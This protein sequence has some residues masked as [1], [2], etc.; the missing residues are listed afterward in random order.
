MG[1]TSISG[2]RRPTYYWGLYNAS[3]EK[4]SNIRWYYTE[5]KG[6]DGTH[7]PRMGAGSQ[8]RFGPGLAPIP[9]RVVLEWS[10]LG[11]PDESQEVAVAEK[12]PDLRK[13]K[14][15]IWLRYDGEDWEAVPMTDEQ[16]TQRAINQVKNATV[17]DPENFP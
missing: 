7:W 4:V 6:G 3:E 10:R 8:A 5:G 2:E 9:E 15:T 17:P 14:G 1:C 16:A 11:H 13:F 12:I